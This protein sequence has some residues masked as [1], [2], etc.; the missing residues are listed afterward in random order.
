V[1][2]LD[3]RAL[4]AWITGHGTLSES[5]REQIDRERESSGIVISVISVLEVGRYID[6]GRLQLSTDKR[7][8]LSALGSIDGL[9]VIPV[10]MAIA[11]RAAAFPTELDFNER[12]IAATA[13]ALDCGLVTPK[14]RLRELV[15]V[16]TIW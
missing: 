14:V 11:V 3:T 7:S 6:S 10:D 13:I 9:Q 1:I 8:W 12:L 4:V 16:E 2:V 15:Y 5:A